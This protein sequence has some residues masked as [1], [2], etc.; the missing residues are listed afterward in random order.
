MATKPNDSKFYTVHALYGDPVMKEL[1]NIK[2]FL[3]S[4]SK[5][6]VV[7]DFQHFYNFSETD[8]NRLLL[9]LKSLFDTMICPYSCPVEKLNLNVMRT[10]CWQV[11]KWISIFIQI[12]LLYSN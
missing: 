11:I 1:V 6:I 10:N 8:H 5:E 4:H 12:I 7:M 9:V 3:V 2:E